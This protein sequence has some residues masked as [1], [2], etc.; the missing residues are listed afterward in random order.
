MEYKTQSIQLQKVYLDNNNP[1]HDPIDNELDLIAN[2]V[3]K[4]K[5]KSLARDIAK[6]GASPLERLAVIPHPTTK[7]VYIAVEGNRRVCALKLLQDPDKAPADSHRKIFRELAA[8]RIEKITTI[9]AVIFP[10]RKSARHWLALRHEGELDGVGT[11]QWR[12]PQVERFNRTGGEITNPNKQA[13]L[14]LEYALARGLIDRNQHDDIS[15]TT[16]TRFLSNPIFRDTIGLSTN[17]D[18]QVSVPQ[19]EFDS[20]AARFLGDAYSGSGSG[21]HS[22]TSKTEREDYARKLRGQ[23]AAPKSRLGEA[24]R[25]NPNA[26]SGSGGAYAGPKKRRNNK[27]P[28]ERSTVIPSAFSVQIRDKLLKRLYDELRTLDAREYSFAA[29]YLV[30][31]MIEQAAKLFCKKKGIATNADLHIIIERCANRLASDGVEARQLKPLRVMASDKD[32]RMSPDT[33]GAYVHG[34][35]IP[36]SVEL[37][38][39]WDSIQSCLVLLIER[40]Q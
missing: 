35:M 3:T 39:F 6:N 28:D 22:R 30:R 13:A 1:R 20:V 23:G 8:S 24:I 2:L 33:L 14:L 25:L 21:V 40:H 19:Q 11:R 34:G 36:N 10:D 29:A 31:A 12:A 17:N 26:G 16:L 4:E 38:R 32:S 18:L 7:S 27:S 15:I 9:D 5:I 37:V